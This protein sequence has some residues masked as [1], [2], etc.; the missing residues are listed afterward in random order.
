MKCRFLAYQNG[1]V[2][3]CESRK[4]WLYDDDD[5]LHDVVSPSN[6]AKS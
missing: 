4:D 2:F 3:A 5:K 1:A 6:E